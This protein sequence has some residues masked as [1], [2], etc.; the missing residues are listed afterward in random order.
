MSEIHARDFHEY[1]RASLRDALLKHVGRDL[2]TP[3]TQ[4]TVLES[5]RQV[6][7][8]IYPEPEWEIDMQCVQDEIDVTISRKQKL[9]TFGFNVNVEG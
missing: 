3:E 4:T 5:L 9:I 1:I 7:G 6:I 8:K 2:N